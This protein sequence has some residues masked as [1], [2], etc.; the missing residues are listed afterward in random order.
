MKQFLFL[1]IACL[2]G[3]T[4]M[5]QQTGNCPTENYF[6]VE[7]AAGATSVEYLTF[8]GTDKV[9]RRYIKTN[10]GRVSGLPS[11]GQYK[12]ANENTIASGVT[13]STLTVTNKTVY[14]V[15]GTYTLTD[16][17]GVIYTALLLKP[18]GGR[19]CY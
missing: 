19:P 12:D 2:V 6:T 1:L 14:T 4:G 15:D 11:A 9:Q 3:F 10:S 13:S 16:S 17:N 8:V 18:V 5:A 7:I